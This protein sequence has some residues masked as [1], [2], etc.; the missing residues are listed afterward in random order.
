M[1]TLVAFGFEGLSSFKV[2][3]IG[4]FTVHRQSLC[5]ELVK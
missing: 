1:S 3:F 5:L 2:S 4:G